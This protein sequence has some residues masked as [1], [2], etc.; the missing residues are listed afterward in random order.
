MRWLVACLLPLLCMSGCTPDLQ[1]QNQYAVART[2]TGGDPHRGSRVISD[3]GCPS[4]HTIP[5]IA[6]ATGLVGPPLT[7]MA[8]RTYIGGVLP[9][10]PENMVR[11][12]R[13]P[14][15]VDGLT[16]MPNLGMNARDARDATA[17]L[18]TLH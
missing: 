17:Y 15:A 16:A 7:K 1:F 4:C 10:T 8:L 11:W 9:N 6:G 13:N 18:Y 3:F 5:G 14:Q 12:L 2:V